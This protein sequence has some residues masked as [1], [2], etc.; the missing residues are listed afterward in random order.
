MSDVLP[1]SLRVLYVVISSPGF[2]MFEHSA[3]FVRRSLH[4]FYPLVSHMMVF[5]RACIGAMACFGLT[6]PKK[7]QSRVSFMGFPRGLR[8]GLRRNTA[9]DRT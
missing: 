8:D 3:L 1:P 9:V 6:A 7:G 4:A 2:S 5:P